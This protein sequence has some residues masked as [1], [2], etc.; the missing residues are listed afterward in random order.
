MGK[1][2]LNTKEAVEELRNLIKEF[3][4]LQ[5]ESKGTSLEFSKLS[6]VMKELNTVNRKSNTQWKLLQKQLKNTKTSQKSYLTQTRKLQAETA[7]LNLE[8]KKLEQQLKKIQVQ[9]KKTKGGFKG[10]ITG[11]RSL[12]GA[13]GIIAGLQIFGNIV[14]SAFKLT[15][16]FDGIRFAMEKITK[17]ANL[18][19]SSQR[20]LKEITDDFG[21][22]LVTTTSRYIKFLA[23]AKQSGLTV[24][25]TE[26][27]FRSMTKAASVLAL[28]TDELR[29]VYLALEQMLS[30]GKVT[31]EELRRQLGERLPGAMGIMAASM[32]VT[33]S[34][35]DK[36]MKKGEV[37]SAEVLPNFAK[38][39]ELAYGIENEERIDTLIAAQNR[40]TNSW[41]NFVKYVYANS[42]GLITVFNSIAEAMNSVTLFFSQEARVDTKIIDK[43]KEIEE[44]IRK[45]AKKA[46]D[47]R[48]EDELKYEAIKSQITETRGKLVKAK[49]IK[50]NDAEIK[51]LEETIREKT[52]LL[53]GYE[54]DIFLMQQDF[55]FKKI[56]A[57]RE[58]LETVTA[59]Y[60]EYQESLESSGFGDAAKKIA[61][62]GLPFFIEKISEN[63]GESKGEIKELIDRYVELKAKD[64]AYSR[65]V[66]QSSAVAPVIDDSDATKKLKDLKDLT[67][68]INNE[69]LKKVI[70]KNKQIIADEEATID[71]KLDLLEVN[72]VSESQIIRNNT[73]DKLKEI[74]RLKSSEYKAVQDGITFEEFKA[75]KIKLINDEMTTELLKIRNKYAK[76][77]EALVKK[78]TD[79]LQKELEDKRIKNET[80]YYNALAVLRNKF[81]GEELKQKEIELKLAFDE[82]ALFDQMDVLEALIET[83]KKLGIPVKDL[84][85]ALAKAR[86]ELEGL[87][88]DTSD[89]DKQK[90][91]FQE[92]LDIAQQFADALGDLGDS[93]FDRKIENINAEIDA[94]TKR[95][96]KL[97]E[98]AEGDAA[99]QAA[100]EEEKQA[101][102][103]ALEK[104]RLKE[105]QKK[106]KFNKAKALVDIAINTA[107]A[108]SRAVAESTF[109][110]LPLIPV[111]T[112]LG[113]LQ[114][115]AVLAQPI[116]KYKEGLKSA[117]E[118]HI[119]MINDGN[120]QEYI[121]R[122]GQILTTE[123]KNAIVGLKAGDTVHK[124]FD[125]MSKESVMF[126][127]LSKGMSVSENDFNKLLNVV[128]IGLEKGFK[129]VKVN[130]KNNIINKIKDNRY[131]ESMSRWN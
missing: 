88:S 78:H 23:A 32:G 108:I 81:D 117:K 113:A 89:I 46:L 51:D 84:E 13:F 3:K 25:E 114:A 56:K 6:S 103:D 31:T 82:I 48:L 86:A 65:L 53:L 11:V 93:I 8:N 130:N 12:L 67:N 109:L 38:A 34:Q 59:K 63:L 94:E 97:L 87:G 128:S 120:Y 79:F 92:T 45:N 74:E 91:A 126:N 28:Q 35:L 19:A 1:A 83:F 36:M 122:N 61:F 127:M 121:E 9:S 30:K 62:G 10:L 27:I 15:K 29:G 18:A 50:D 7:K 14:K 123:T 77:E 95:Y 125:A 101:R 40:L 21:V 26:N 22:S 129:N 131:E 73:N 60:K 80:N 57:N 69:M 41:Q 71:L 20:F 75:S 119:A 76:D 64:D 33:I 68:K 115:A 49:L 111:L 70:E 105:E 99:Q 17:D 96:D 110:G 52:S 72:A 5:Q 55:A 112:A 102:L 90:K 54:E 2:N 118:D 16:T 85:L 24:L 124:N 100:L 37:L 98:L 104:K 116:P 58:E 42:R 66:E 107:V 44:T 43:K 47:D 106:A 4:I 39:V